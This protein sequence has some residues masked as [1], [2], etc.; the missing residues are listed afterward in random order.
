MILKNI[1]NKN[2]KNKNIEEN[3]SSQKGN[4][5]EQDVSTAKYN[6]KYAR[7]KGLGMLSNDPHIKRKR[8]MVHKM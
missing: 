8:I 3:I 7:K 1:K 5:N 6:D 2:I 4:I